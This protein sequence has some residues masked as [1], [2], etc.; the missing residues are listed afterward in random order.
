MREQG[1]GR[2]RSEDSEREIGYV[3]H[4]MEIVRIGKVENKYNTTVGREI[5][6]GEIEKEIDRE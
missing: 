1:R 5:R 2:E 6:D 3:R 4:S